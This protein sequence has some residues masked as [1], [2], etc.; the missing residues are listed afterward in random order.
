MFNPCIEDIWKKEREIKFCFL[1][2]IV[3]YFMQIMDIS[4]KDKIKATI[5]NADFQRKQ[6][7]LTFWL[8]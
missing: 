8:V 1:A 7:L 4:V 5:L 3:V 2:E 6:I